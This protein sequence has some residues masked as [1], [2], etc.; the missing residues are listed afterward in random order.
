MPMRLSMVSMSKSSVIKDFQKDFY[1]IRGHSPLF[2]DKPPTVVGN[3]QVHVNLII[4][5]QTYVLATRR[6]LNEYN[7]N[8]KF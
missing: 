8:E 1:V 5:Y 7:I 6:N 2:K 4:L 3:T